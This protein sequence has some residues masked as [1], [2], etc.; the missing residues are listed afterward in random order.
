MATTSTEPSS[1]SSK[2]SSSDGVAVGLAVASGRTASDGDRVAVGFAMAMGT[3][4][5][6]ADGAISVAAALETIACNGNDGNDRDDGDNGEEVG[7]S[8]A[9]ASIHGMPG[10]MGSS[11]SNRAVQTRDHWKK[12]ESVRI[13]RRTG[14]TR[15]RQTEGASWLIRLAA[16][17]RGSTISGEI[18]ATTKVMRTMAVDELTLSLPC[19][20][21][22]TSAP[23]IA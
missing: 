13:T 18:S 22:E 17:A 1:P 23:S 7:D 6:A 10:L 4:A 16:L 3:T 2:P 14:I 21:R 9:A 15:R 20:I 11:P 8:I 5:W 19:V 12:R